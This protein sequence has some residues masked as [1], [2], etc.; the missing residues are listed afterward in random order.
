[1]IK[2]IVFDLGNVLV[3]FNPKAFLNEMIHDE[4]I[5][6]QLY[7]FYFESN[8]WQIYDQ[9]ILTNEQMIQKGIQTYP[10][11]EQWIRKLMNEWVEYV[12]P[13]QENLEYINSLQQ[14]NQYIVSDIPEYNYLYLMENFNFLKTR[15]GIYSFQEKIVKP[16]KKMFTQLEEK[17]K[18]NPRESVFID[19][20]IENVQAAMQVGFYGIHL[21]QPL[22][23]KNELEEFLHEM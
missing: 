23:L 9:G 16:N 11:Y 13:I 21:K 2:N 10:Q 20:K 4:L 19:D 18:I 17:Y 6:K 22:N 14:Y 5:E 8:L 1:M 15:K 3:Q 7:S 12:I